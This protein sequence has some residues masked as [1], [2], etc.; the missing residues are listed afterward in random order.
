M[1]VSA[2]LLSEVC[3]DVAIEPLLTPLTGEKF[4]FKSAIREDHARL[5]VA[6]RGVFIRRNRAFGDIKVFNPL[7][8]VYSKQ[9]LKAAH[10]TNEN[11]K[12][13]SYGERV[14]NVEHGTFT[15]LVFSCLG[16]MSVEC[17]HFFNHLADKYG[18][19]HNWTSSKARTWVRTKLNFCLLKATHL[20][21]RGSRTKR[22]FYSQD[23]AETNVTMAME[24]AKM[25][26]EMME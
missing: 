13:R 24:N 18:E 17:T 9:T 23:L 26:T 14:V 2:E 1:F 22:Q 11:G 6:A 10:K 4:K 19:K 7:A 15:P 5:D 8:Q 20:C 12:K 21:I 3:N 16:G 25:D